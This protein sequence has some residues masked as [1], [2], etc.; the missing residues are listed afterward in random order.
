MNVI[1]L[2]NFLENMKCVSLAF[3][4]IF[5][6]ISNLSTSET[7]CLPPNPTFQSCTNYYINLFK[8]RRTLVNLNQDL[9][10]LDSTSELDF[11][12]PFFICTT[13]RLYNV[14]QAMQERFLRVHTGRLDAWMG[15]CHEHHDLTSHRVGY[16]HCPTSSQSITNLILSFIVIKTKQNV[17]VI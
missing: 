16:F 7:A 9:P 5:T 10:T 2:I 15:G 12:N 8:L 1:I 11:R 6:Q 3:N 4:D 13:R 14:G 17:S